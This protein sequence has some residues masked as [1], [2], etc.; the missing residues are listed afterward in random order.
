MKNFKHFVAAAL[1]ASATATVFAASVKEEILEA[2]AAEGEEQEK[3]RQLQAQINFEL[4]NKHGLIAV[5]V[6]NVKKGFRGF[7]EKAILLNKGDKFPT[8]IDTTTGTEIKFWQNVGD[9]SPA[10][11]NKMLG[12]YFID[13]TKTRG[14]KTVFVTFGPKDGKLQLYRQTGPGYG[15]TGKT[16]SGLPLKNNIETKDITVFQRYSEARGISID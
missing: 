9:T 15:V 6:S 5:S 1:L 12:S 8:I 14:N 16:D 4:Q 11:G 10:S 13:S 2:R 3:L 7:G